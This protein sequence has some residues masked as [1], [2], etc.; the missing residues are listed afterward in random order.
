MYSAN[1]QKKEGHDRGGKK[2]AKTKVKQKK[3]K[4]HLMGELGNNLDCLTFIEFPFR[5]FKVVSF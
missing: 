2:S 3:V 5:T 4:E 1:T